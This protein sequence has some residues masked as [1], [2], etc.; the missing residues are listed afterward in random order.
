MK[1]MK[2]TCNISYLNYNTKLPVYASISLNFYSNYNTGTIFCYW[3]YYQLSPVWPGKTSI[4]G[5]SMQNWELKNSIMTTSFSYTLYF[6]NA[7]ENHTSHLVVL[8]IKNKSNLSSW[9]KHGTPMFIK[10]T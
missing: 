5:L 8:M 2:S 7:I 1:Y 10:M 3:L 4:F 6:V 9:S